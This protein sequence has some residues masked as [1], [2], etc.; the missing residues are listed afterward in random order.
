MFRKLFAALVFCSTTRSLRL[1]QSGSFMCLWHAMMDE[2]TLATITVHNRL[3]ENSMAYKYLSSYAPVCGLAGF[4]GLSHGAVVRA[5]GWVRTIA[6]VLMQGPRLK[7][8]R[9]HSRTSQ[10]THWNA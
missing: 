10:G 6:R 4:A 3:P 8:Q 1:F 9:T 5:V 7:E 2:S